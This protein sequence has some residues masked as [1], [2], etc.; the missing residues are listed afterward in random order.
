MTSS[1]EEAKALG[2]LLSYILTSDGGGG[3][4]TVNYRD[5]IFDVPFLA[6]SQ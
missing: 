3:V 5:V 2:S 6:I 4:D 1:T